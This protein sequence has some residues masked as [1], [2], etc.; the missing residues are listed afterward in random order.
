MQSFASAVAARILQMPM[1]GLGN[2]SKAPGCPSEGRRLGG[3]KKVS[4]IKRDCTR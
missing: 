1:Q 3:N 2:I 4:W